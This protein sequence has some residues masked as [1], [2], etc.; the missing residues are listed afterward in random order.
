M[1]LT[2]GEITQISLLGA[3]S[4][5]SGF[6]LIPL[7]PVPF[8]LQTLFVL[9]TGLLLNPRAAFLSQL[10]HLLLK[11]LIGGGQ[12][13]L[14]PSFGFLFGFIAAATVMAYLLTKQNK[15]L[16]SYIMAAA[17]GSLAIYLVGLPYMA[18]ILNGYLG[19][20]YS[21]TKIFWM[22]M[23]LFIPGD[24][25]KAGLAVVIAIR[26]KKHIPVLP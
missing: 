12:S 19:A 8:T 4:F 15:G 10:L 6:V 25:L 5:I 24:L 1:K 22:G 23:G 14:S 26:L 3:L 18:A 20:G 17:V 11:L 21:I 7:G 13:F 9:L 2:T 16:S